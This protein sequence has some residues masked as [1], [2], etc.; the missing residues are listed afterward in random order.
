MKPSQKSAGL[1]ESA[2]NH[3]SRWAEGYPTPAASPQNGTEGNLRDTDGGA[4]GE[5]RFSESLNG[6][7]ITPWILIQASD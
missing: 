3:Q 4:A 5:T 6:K 1:L 7:P 2:G